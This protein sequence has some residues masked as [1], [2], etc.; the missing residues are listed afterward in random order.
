MGEKQ[1]AIL[2][3]LFLSKFLEQPEEWYAFATLGD[4]FLPVFEV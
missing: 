1:A 2:I 3:L 4:I